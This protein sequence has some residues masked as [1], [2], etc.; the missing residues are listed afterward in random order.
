[1]DHVN[2]LFT[3]FLLEAQ[4]V[5]RP[6]GIVVAK[7]ADLVH[8]HLYQWQHVEFIN[9]ATALGMNPCDVAIKV[10]PASGNLASSKWKRV[11][12]LRRAHLYWIVVRA[13]GSCETCGRVHRSV[14]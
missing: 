12:H 2:D 7:I 14:A 13:D 4:R 8:N 9:A 5:L 10:D 3:P 1:M 11:L 6:R